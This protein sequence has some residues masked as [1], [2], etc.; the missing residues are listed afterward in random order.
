MMQNSRAHLQLWRLISPTLPIGAYA[1]SQGLEYA[2]E[3]GWVEDEQDTQDW[4]LGLMQHTVGF[5]DVPIL[6]RLYRAWQQNDENELRHWNNVLQASREASEL[7][8]EDRQLGSALAK[9]LKDL[10]LPDVASIY[11]ETP[12]SY[13]TLFACAAV[14]WAISLEETV[15]AYL[16]SWSE[17]QVVAAIKLVPLGQTAGQR[18]LSKVIEMI[19]P[20]AQ[21]GLAIEDEEIG[22]SAPGLAIAS[23]RH[24]TQYS[25]LFRS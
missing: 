19:P 20:V 2:I 18:I 17:N 24:E 1:Y 8:A 22:M 9:L 23:A 7:L 3:Q 11:K 14:H 13:A 10:S 4:I 25:R 6:I 16:W 12:V 15:E 5:V 21:Q